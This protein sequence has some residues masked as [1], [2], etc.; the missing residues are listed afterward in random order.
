LIYMDEVGTP[1][2]SRIWDAVAYRGGRIVENSKE[3][4]RQALLRHVKDPQLLLDH[5]RFAERKQFAQE[6]TL[7]VGMLHSLSETYRAVAER[8]TGQ[9][10]VVPPNPRESMMS[11]LQDQFALVN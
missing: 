5:A 4:F 6:H 8:I 11:V 9:P 10:L 2:S 7:P 3:E 1:D